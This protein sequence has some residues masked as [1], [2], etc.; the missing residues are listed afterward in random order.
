MKA[1]YCIYADHI[2]N[3]ISRLLFGHFM[4]HAG[5]II[6]GGIFDPDHPMADGDGFREDVCAAIREAGA[7]TLRYPG[8]NFVSNYHW[9][10]GIGPVEKRPR[11]FD[12]AWLTEEDNRVGTVEFIRLCRKVNAE[13]YI[14]VNMGSGTAEEAMHWVEFCNGSGNTRY[15]K[16]RREMGEAEPFH[17]KYW[18]LG[19]EM[20]GDW[21]FASCSAEDYAK[22]AKDFAKAMKWADPSIELVA[23]GYDID[24]DWNRI[25]AAKLKGLA[26]HIAI[27]HYSIGYG[28]FDDR[29]YAQCMYIPEYLGKLTAACRAS[30]VAGTNDALSEIKVAWDEWNTYGWNQKGEADEATYTLSNAILT[31]LIL[32][33]FVKHS[34][35]VEIASYSPFVNKCGAVRCTEEGVLRR[36][37]FYVFREFFEAFSKC[38]GYV[39]SYMQCE[40]VPVSEVIDF[41]NR[42]PEPK[43]SLDEMPLRRIVETPYVDAA[44]ALD[45]ERK[46]LVISVIN[47]HPEEDCEIGVRLFGAD[48]DWG[49]GKAVEIYADEMDAANSFREPEKVRS[50]E[51]DGVIGDG[52]I[53]VRKHSVTVCYLPIC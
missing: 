11:V 24:S 6:Y 12:Y 51:A 46:T 38:D 10:D 36:A 20:Y 42:L 2:R 44:A 16:M 39:E 40:A 17:V 49:A 30:I 48:V 34:D 50:R 18:G 1:T 22:K 21:Q 31:A 29:D 9:E 8:G 47:K 35:V 19:N 41:S 52:V 15:A 23:A 53:R 32:Q 14:C 4:E 7:A 25:V 33:S 27:H 37:Q 3:R 26:D 45:E 43:F 13:P 5:D 28:V